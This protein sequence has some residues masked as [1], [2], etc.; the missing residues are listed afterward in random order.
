SFVNDGMQVEPYY[1]TA[2]TD[3]RD[4]VLE[5]FKPPKP[6]ERVMSAE[7]AA[8]ILEMLKRVVNEGTGVSLRT[9]YGFSNDIAG[10]TGT[11]QSNADG[12]IM[13]LTTHK[14]VGTWVG[15]SEPRIH[16]RT[17]SHGQGSPTPIPPHT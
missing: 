16:D 13:A 7:N 17:S 3:R 14:V 12:W 10:K 11:T 5:R 4:S 6:D 1:I 15:A 2:I 8:L 9:R